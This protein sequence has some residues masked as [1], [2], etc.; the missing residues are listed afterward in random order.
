MKDRTLSGKDPLSVIAH[1]Q[2]FR[3]AYDTCGIREGAAMCLFTKI[4]TSRDKV[5]LKARVTLT[6]SVKLCHE[7]PLKLYFGM[8]RY[9][10]NRYVTDDNT[11]NLDAKVRY[12]RKRLM[13]TAEC[14]R[15][16]WTQSLK[17]VSL[18][19]EKSVK[20]LVLEEIGT[21]CVELCDITRQSTNS[22][23]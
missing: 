21:R 13:T 17:S 18:Y 4:L 22:N 11:A 14:A 1:L 15:K 23:T 16:L 8:I 12:L 19:D 2:N 5:A 6:S 9:I 3:S 10:L 7:S 20:T